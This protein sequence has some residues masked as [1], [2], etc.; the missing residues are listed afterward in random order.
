[1]PSKVLLAGSDRMLQQMASTFDAG[2]IHT[3]STGDGYEAVC[4]LNENTPDLLIAEIGLPQ[5]DAYA[6]CRYVRQEP[7]FQTLPVILLDREFSVF[8]QRR[9]YAVGADVYLSQ[10]LSP[11]ELI[12]NVHR[13]LTSKTAADDEVTDNV[14]ALAAP[15]AMRPHLIAE[16]ADDPHASTLHDEGAQPPV[17]HERFGN[18]A[19]PPRLAV[20]R[21]SPFLF[22]AVAVAAILVA[23]S[24][25]LLMQ[26]PTADNQAFTTEK[27]SGELATTGQPVVTAPEPA[28]QAT[29]DDNAASPSAAAS[30][31]TSSSDDA[32]PDTASAAN[33]GDQDTNAAADRD[34]VARAS[35]ANDAQ[36]NADRENPSKPA[37]TTA[38]RAP[39]MGERRTAAPTARTYARRPA[40]ANHWRRGGEEMVASGEHFGSSAK[41]F[42]KGSANVAMWAGR[43]AGS[44]V[45]RIG[46]ALKR[47]F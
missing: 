31:V 8:N 46:S 19:M 23:I 43:K 5:K 41:H 30:S 29:A 11:D 22:A 3:A 7:E 25:A 37:D 26:R 33:P 21:P 27:A 4:L 15:L 18:E 2:Q 36:T 40:R 1:M 34:T 16:A 24:L 6:L 47:I 20:R 44:G 14:D 13:L 28:T 39:A 38:V 9:A 10:P 42:G 12:E 17:A 35:A 32:A 45:K